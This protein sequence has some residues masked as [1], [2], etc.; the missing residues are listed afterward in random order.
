MKKI[1]IGIF[2]AGRGK[3]LAKAFMLAG[4]D[5]VALCD[6][7]SERLEKAL[8]EL[9]NGIKSYE[10]FDEFIKHPMDGV[11]LANYFHEHAPYA[12]KC[13][14]KGIPVF[15][16]CISNGCMA[17]GVALA[18]AA[19]KYNSIYMLAENY[20]F[21]LF[22]MEMKRICDGGTLGR[23]LYAEGEYNH[24][25]AQQDYD[26]FRENVYYPEHWRNYLPRAYYVT[27]SL[28]PLMRATGAVPK[29][30][31]AFS[32]FEPPAG[33]NIP[34]A[35]Y[36]GDRLAVIMSKN[37]DGSVFKFTGCAAMG[38]GHIALRVQTA[39]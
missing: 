24:P 21:M 31:C 1:R 10:S 11:L 5:I 16:E 20:P 23:I 14:E 12:I 2:G 30:V 4:A 38:A 6:F 3:Y 35:S 32:V 37:D 7:N 34:T 17:E 27:H 15:S 19:K 18:R 25:I 8:G 28:A 9:G 36:N 22:N 26:F 33:D 39:R 29:R 13:M